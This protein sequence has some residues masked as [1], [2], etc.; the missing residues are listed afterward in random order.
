VRGFFVEENNVLVVVVVVVVVVVERN[1]YRL[2]NDEYYEVNKR[3]DGVI[4]VSLVG[5][6]LMF[7][8]DYDDDVDDEE[9]DD[10]AE[11][12]EY[13]LVVV[14]NLMEFR[15]MNDQNNANLDWFYHEKISNEI[16]KT[17]FFLY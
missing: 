9:N 15:L 4:F 14:N 12:Y 7:D 2:A 13:L 5:V 10:L 3:I 8:F 11:F 1:S 16:K 6:E 17:F